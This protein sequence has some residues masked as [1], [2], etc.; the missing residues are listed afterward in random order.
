MDTNNYN[1]TYI[2]YMY[3]RYNHATVIMTKLTFIEHK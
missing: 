2:L 3:N 1:D